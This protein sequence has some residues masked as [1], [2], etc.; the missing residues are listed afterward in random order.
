MRSAFNKEVLRSITHSWGRFLAI[1]VIAALGT[2]FYAGLRMTCPDMNLAGD[3][4]YDGGNFCDLRIVSTLGFAEDQI[5]EISQVDGVEGVMPAYEADTISEVAGTQYAIRFHSLNIDAAKASTCDDG[6]NVQSSD[7]N[8]IN[9]PILLEGSWPSASNECVLSGD[10]VWQSQVNI[11]DAVKVVEG[12][13]DLEDTFAVTEYTVVGFVRCAYYTSQTSVGTTSLGSGSLTSFIYVPEDSFAEDYPYTE[14]FVT[15]EG[16]REAQWPTDEYQQIVDAVADKISGI[17]G[18]LATSR[19]DGLVDA[20]QAELD[21]ARAE[22][23]SERAD[24][25]AQLADGQAELDDA[26]AQLDDAKA[27]L[28]SASSQLSSSQ[29]TISQ[30]EQSLSSGWSQYYSGVSELEEKKKQAQDAIASA[31][32]E[33]DSAQAQYDSAMETRASLVSQLDEVNA[34]LSQLASGIEQVQ[35]G[36]TQAEAGVAQLQ[37]AKAALDPTAAGYDQQVAAIDAQIAEAQTTLDGLNAQLTQL[38][39]QQTEAQSGAAQLEAGIGQ[40]DTQTAGVLEQIQSGRDQLSQQEASANAQI[41]SGQAQLDEALSQLQ[42]GEAQLSSGKS[43]LE[44]GQKEYASG[45]KEYSDGLAEYQDG[46]AEYAD[47]LAEAQQGFADAEAELAKAQADIDELA[48]TDCEVY[49]LDRTKNVG[50]ESFKSDASR[51]NQIAQVFPLFFFLVAA[52][53]SLTTMTRMVDEERVLI[54]TYKALGYSNA[55]ITSKYI[56]YAVVASGVGSLVGIVA[57]SIFL[58]W[59]IM[60]AYSIIYVVPCRPT[61]IDLGIAGLSAGLGVG[62]TVAATWFA[63]VATLRERP[64]LLMLPRAPKAGKRI[65]LE[66]IR[67]LW[68]RMSFSWKVTARNIFRYK[69]RFFM[70]IVGIAGCTGLLLTG[71]GLQN[72]INDI[73]DKQWGELY[74]YNA[75][76]RL[77][78][79][80]SESDKHSVEERVKKDTTGEIAW[81]AT[82]NRIVCKAEGESPAAADKVG[83]E[84]RVELDVPEDAGNFSSFNTLRTRVGHNELNLSDDGVLISEKLATALGV[85]AGDAIDIYEEDTIGNIT[86]DGY[87]VKVSG[88]MEHYVY[89]YVLMTPG[90]YKSTFGETPTYAT[91]YASVDENED[92]RD[93]FSDDLLGMDSVKTLTF[94]DET[95]DTYRTMLTSVD[96]V[97]VVLVVAAALLAFVVLYNLTNINITERAREIATLKVLGFTPHEVNAYIYRETLLL[98]FI[99]AVL[100]CFV[101]IVMEGYV[102]VTAEVDQVMFGRDIHALSF[103]IAFALTMLF[104]VIVTVAMRKKLRDI[105]M[106]ESLKSNE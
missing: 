85:S 73:I 60:G 15:V 103:V 27:Q 43:Q 6:V 1:A 63:A 23:E 16:A 90:L 101:G 99:G 30:S 82:S 51:V 59:F 8:Y 54:G 20:A 7:E 80:A 45:Q 104:S 96:S 11:G 94:N 61:P 95:I 98:A 106:V 68:R 76:V 79:D 2:G 64:A 72:A 41:A 14:A 10:T 19:V 17:S 3:E 88:V 28:D 21:D 102:I 87:R 78:D 93:V 40:I 18:D 86:G 31:R 5:D 65:L 74:H 70:A 13:Q 69:R 9:R 75:I 4:Y 44:S 24:A 77:D 39:A 53:V 83:N 25:E 47:K 33:L 32:A 42:S 12:T 91:I 46:A 62:I 97:V 37:A 36:I 92:A 58:P 26:K 35:A 22:Y 52:L 34:G 71:L 49:V 89:Q 100:G 50:A 66:R 67:P 55:R 38:Q 48:D 84:Q 56:I 81:L 105:D 57:L 29:S